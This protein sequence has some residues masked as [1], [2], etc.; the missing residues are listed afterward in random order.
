MWN[1]TIGEDN[2]TIAHDGI[3]MKKFSLC[4]RQLSLMSLRNQLFEWRENHWF[5]LT[6]TFYAL[7]QHSHAVFTLIIDKS[8][9]MLPESFSETPGEIF[10]IFGELNG[11]SNEN[12]EKSLKDIP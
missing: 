10:T 7:Q 4:Y 6:P 1:G 5:Q 11:L 12:G 2:F 9:I 8:E 3:T